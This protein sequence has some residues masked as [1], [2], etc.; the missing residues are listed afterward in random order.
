MKPKT[1]KQDMKAVKADSLRGKRE[2]QSYRS[3]DMKS[4][5]KRTVFNECTL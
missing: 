2:E 4:R 5:E 3:Y 1:E